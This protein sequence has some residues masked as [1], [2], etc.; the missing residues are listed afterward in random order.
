MYILQFRKSKSKHFPEALKLAQE[1]G[2]SYDGTIV[3]LE[4][5]DLLNAYKHIRTLF[6]I[7]Q[8]WKSTKAT[9]N[10]KPVQSYQ[11]ILQAHWI[12]D[13]YDEALLGR[14]CGAGWE[15][16]KLDKIKY[17]L[18]VQYFKSH[19]YWYQFGEWKG[20]KWIINKQDIFNNLIIYATNK[21]IS[22]CPFFDETKLQFIVGNLPDFLIADGITFETVFSDKYLN[23]EI[24]QVPVGI[25][26]LEVDSITKNLCF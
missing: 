22:L 12:G 25:K 20:K 5:S 24:L 9:Y 17:E 11:F 26:H 16:L 19:R 4:I 8:N 15:C 3:T 10:G 13:C 7:I 18:P 23:G 6:G 2:A 1:F 14:S 21:G